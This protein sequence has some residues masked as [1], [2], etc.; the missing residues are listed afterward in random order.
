VV[1]TEALPTTFEFELSQVPPAEQPPS[2]PTPTQPVPFS[3]Q[4]TQVWNNEREAAAYGGESSFDPD[5]GFGLVATCVFCSSRLDFG[6][7]CTCF[8]FPASEYQHD[9]STIH[10]SQFNMN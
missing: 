9:G 10:L 5:D 1:P 6:Q 4:Q 8:R 2:P 3:Q 7:R